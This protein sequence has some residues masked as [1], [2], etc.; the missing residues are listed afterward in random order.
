MTKACT[1]KKRSLL[2]KGIDLIKKRISSKKITPEPSLFSLSKTRI[3]IYESELQFIGAE[4][5]VWETETGGDLFGIWNKQP[6]IYL[7]TR[8]GPNSIREVA[9][10][11]LDV[12][13]LIKLSGKLNNE[14]GLC[15]FGDWHSHHRL[16]LDAPS[17]GD[18]KRI[19]QVASKNKFDKM[20]E[21][22]ATLPTDYQKTKNVHIHPYL[23]EDP[24]K[25]DC[26]KISLDIIEGISPIRSALIA[27]SS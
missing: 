25:I 17:G 2:S 22:I 16:G 6:I 7:A 12:E 4:S 21:I 19:K 1:K 9:H 20:A 27:S 18:K 24:I 10:F 15:Y 23:Y 11:K 8:T 14:W 13:Y 5:A 3:T 26:I